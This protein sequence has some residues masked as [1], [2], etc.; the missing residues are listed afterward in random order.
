MKI[1]FGT[2]NKRKIEDLQNLINSLKLDI[3]VLGM[4]DIGWDRGD[5]EENGTTINEN[6]LIKAN[7]IHSFCTQKNIQYP[8][9]TDDAG[10][11]CDA[12]AGKPGIFTARYAEDELKDNPELPKH[13]CVIKLLRELK[14]TTNRSAYYKCAVTYMEPNG[15]YFQEIGQSKGEIANDIIGELKKPYFYSVF[16]LDGTN[17]AFSDITDETILNNTYRYAALR[18]ILTRTNDKC[19][20]MD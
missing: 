18:K 14:N 12:L 13:Q 6:S 5:I 10:L 19:I 2:T 8:I 9:I 1:V 20:E 3:Q 17:R 4:N 15:E 16:V 11:F 7:A